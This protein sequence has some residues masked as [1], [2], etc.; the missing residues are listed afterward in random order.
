MRL[1]ERSMLRIAE[2]LRAD[3]R[4]ENDVQGL[5]ESFDDHVAHRHWLKER[6]AT[7]TAPV[8]RVRFRIGWAGRIWR[9]PPFGSHG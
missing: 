1:T 7:A 3:D 2:D 8:E 9:L 6:S 5:V 4:G